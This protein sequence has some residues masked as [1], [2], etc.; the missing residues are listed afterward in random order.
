MERLKKGR[1]GEEEKAW[2]GRGGEGIV[3]RDNRATTADDEVLRRPGLKG[4]DAR[5]SDV[6]FEI[7]ACTISQS[8]GGRGAV[9]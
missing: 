9:A 7:K 4:W 8:M 5:T 6:L 2:D 1:V 3:A